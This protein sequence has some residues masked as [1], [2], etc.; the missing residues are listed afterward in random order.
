[1]PFNSNNPRPFTQAN[2]ES[3]NPDQWGV[4]GLYRQAKW[5]YIGSGDIRTRLL[6]HLRGENAADPCI[7][8]EAPT[9]WIDEVTS[10][11]AA[12]ER[13]LILECG[14]SCNQRVG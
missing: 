10:N 9:H 3:L 6:S 12:R 5:V 7:A 11:Y 1:V 14:P 13:E 2:V 4:Y 8:A